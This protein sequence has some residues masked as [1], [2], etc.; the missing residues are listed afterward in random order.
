[1][2]GIMVAA[3]AVITAV[4]IMAAVVTTGG[5]TITAGIII[6]EGTITTDTILTITGTDI[7]RTTMAGIIRI[8]TLTIRALI[9]A[10]RILSTNCAK[11][12]EVFPVGVPA[13]AGMACSL[14]RPGSMARKGRI[15]MVGF[16]L[17]TRHRQSSVMCI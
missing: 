17:Y 10:I 4:D 7:I 2:A 1:M 9:T 11:T 14:A 3:E 13:P 5:I 6:M 12:L 15:S 16:L 8:I